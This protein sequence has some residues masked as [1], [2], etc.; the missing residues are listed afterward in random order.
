M[1]A[2]C[3]STVDNRGQRRRRFTVE[4]EHVGT[5]DDFQGLRR[6]LKTAWRSYNLRCI[7]YATSPPLLPTLVSSESSGLSVP[8]KVSDA[9]GANVVR[10]KRKQAT[11]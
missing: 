1:K 3:L 5:G 10:Q 8:P 2:Q 6:W 4:L 9:A 11:L 7:S